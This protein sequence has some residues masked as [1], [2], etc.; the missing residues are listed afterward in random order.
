MNQIK[1]VR[2]IFNIGIEQIQHNLDYGLKVDQNKA[3]RAA[4]KKQPSKLPTFTE[5]HNR[6]NTAMI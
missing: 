4:H 1:K 2:K 5:E 6:S 3:S